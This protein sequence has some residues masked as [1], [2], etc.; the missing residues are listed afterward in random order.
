MNPRRAFAALLVSSLVWSAGFAAAVKD[1]EGAVRG[2]KAA[3]END[4]RWIY[5]DVDRGFAEAKKTGKPVLVVLR[6]VPCLSCVGLDAEVLKEPTL[7]P[8]LDQFVCVRLINAN[9]IDLARFQFDYDLSFSTLFFNADGTI[10]GRYGSWVHQADPEAK[11]TIGYRR[12]LEGA[13]AIHRGYPQNGVTLAGKQGAPTPFRTPVEIPVLA[14]KYGRE[15]N[16]NGKVVQS[17][18]HCHQVG[19]AFRTYYREKGETVPLERIYPLPASETVGLSLAA[20][21]EATITA[22]AAGSLGAAAGFR[23]GDEV[24]TFGG[25][26][27][28]SIADFS[29]VLHRAPPAGKVPAIVKRS[30]T[31]I[32]LTLTLP[33]GWRMKTEISKRVGTWSMRAMAFGGLTLVDLDDVA[34]KDRG[35]GMEKMALFVKGMGQFNKHGT[36]KKVGFLK[37]DVIVEFAGLAAR[38]SEGELI[39]QVL[40]KTKIGE[41]VEVT[42]LRR[43]ERVGL[44]LP[45]Q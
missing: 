8:L 39:G 26:P 20:D 38:A 40:A 13:L 33:E 19:E 31:E 34:R 21:K 1:R 6:C 44:K 10:Y 3:M 14:E 36:A 28:I 15:L 41:T 2:D 9:A 24:V 35:L 45:M 18:V 23:V 27:L 29:W 43:G 30:G 37:D 11:E 12:A 42:V 7:S 22:V 17:C 32:A 4:A 5:N 25:Q 16:W